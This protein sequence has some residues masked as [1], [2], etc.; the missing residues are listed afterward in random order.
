MPSHDFM[1]GFGWG[2]IAATVIVTFVFLH[3]M[4]RLIELFRPLPDDEERD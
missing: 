3:L 2:A 1:L 4:V